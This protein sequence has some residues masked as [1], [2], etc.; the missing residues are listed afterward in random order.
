[1]PR[2]IIIA[3]KCTNWWREMKV[4]L[5]TELLI[6]FMFSGVNEALIFLI[7]VRCVGWPWQG[8][9][10]EWGRCQSPHPGSHSEGNHPQAAGKRWISDRGLAVC[11]WS[12]VLI[13]VTVLIQACHWAGWTVCQASARHQQ[14]VCRALQPDVDE[15]VRWGSVWMAI[16]YDLRCSWFLCVCAFTYWICTEGF[17]DLWRF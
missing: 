8:R 2:R 12:S 7:I 9:A 1:M 14:P 13:T 5:S 11:L 6:Y 15:D 3:H 17:E 10:V 4:V 16:E